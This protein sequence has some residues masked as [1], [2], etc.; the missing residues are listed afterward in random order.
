MKRVHDNEALGSAKRNRAD[1]EER[2]EV[3]WLID[4]REMGAVIGKGGSTVKAIRDES[5]A[6]V[7]ILKDRDL[8]KEAQK[9]PEKVMLIGSTTVEKVVHAVRLVAEALLLS[10]KQRAERHEDGG[11]SAAVTEI[12]NLKMLVHELVVG[13]IIGKGGATIKALAADTGARVQISKEALVGSTEKSV[14]LSGSAEQV[15][16]ATASIMTALEEHPLRPGSRMVH[17]NP[18]GPAYGAAMGRQAPAG[19]YG[20]QY[21]APPGAAPTPYANYSPYG[22][23]GFSPFDPYAAAYAAQ[24]GALGGALGGAPYA[25]QAA[26]FPAAA[27]MPTLPQGAARG[28]RTEGATPTGGAKW[29][30]PRAARDGQEQRTIAIP[31]QCAGSVIGKRGAVIKDLSA[32][33]GTTLV[34]ADADAGN[35]GERLVTITGSAEGIVL[36]TE[37]IRQIVEQGFS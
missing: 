5:G 9:T 10:S 4:A 26:G 37:L 13:A 18:A 11:A 24:G 25:A 15:S 34:I 36:A 8:P 6:F 31:T 22:D 16:M 30:A 17:Y 2:I 7:S 33:S 29:A 23:A 12:V 20:A 27:R 35:P 19:A 32:R 14:T 3:R 28:S 21:G 1:D